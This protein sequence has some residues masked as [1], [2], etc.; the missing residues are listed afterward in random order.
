MP[1]IVMRAVVVIIELGELMI[2]DAYN[3][4]ESCGGHYRVEY[5]EEGEA[6][7]DD[8]N[9]AYVAAWQ[10]NGTDA[11]PTMHREDLKFENIKLQTRSYK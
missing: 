9:F 3:R 4:D 7:R 6:K 2:T 10:F 11:E 1:T 5:N 8:A